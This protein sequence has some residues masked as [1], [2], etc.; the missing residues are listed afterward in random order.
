MGKDRDCALVDIGHLRELDLGVEVPPSP[1]TAV[2]SHEVWEEI[3]A[4][5]AELI[6]AHTT[7]LIFVNTRKMA[8]R[9]AA[10]LTKILGP[11][12]VTS[13]HGSLSRKHRL[14]AEQRLKEG[15]L[16]ALVATAS[17]ELGIDVGD[18]D[19]S[20]QVGASR[21]IATF[22]QR[23]GRAGHALRKTPKGRIFPLTLDE[24]VEAAAILR[25][26]RKGVLDRTPQPPAPL[27]ILA[28]QVVASCVPGPWEADRLYGQFRRAW[29]YRDL[30]REDF[31]RV[32]ELHAQ[33]RRAL[34]HR[35]GVGGRILATKRARLT[36][37]MSGGAIPDTAD[38]QVVMEPEGSPVGTVN[39]DFAIESNAG[40][41]FQLGNTSWRILK[42]EPGTVRVAD[43]KGQP[44]T[45]PFWTGEA[46][47]RT[48]ELSAEIAKIREEC[49][50]PDWVVRETGM[51]PASASQ[52]AE[53]VSAGRSALGGAPTQTRVILERFFDESG[54]MQLVVHAP[55]G[56]RINR[57][58]GLAL[59]KRFCR[60]FGFE[61]QAAANEEAI[62]LSLGPQHSFALEEVF[63]FLH[64]NTA[65]ALLVQA[66]LAAPMFGVRWRWNVTRSLLVER[67]TGGKRSPPPSSG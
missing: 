9:I 13:H 51:D 53:Y 39:E 8:E 10:R 12:A 46:P 24:L 19:L 34:L 29:P 36:A 21:S 32:V 30:P 4:R 1:L 41:I 58:W 17:L 31:D 45:L 37:I 56:G 3:Y 25:S 57:A 50:G 54:G 66:L 27:D 44:P 43:A 65:R 11:E 40:D 48:A 20:L 55:F 59:R 6:A 61:L 22:L 42:V 23:A 16:R 33:G 52:V 38:Y 2:C 49:T 14:E 26:I 67:M 47:A 60:G 63:D 35:D 18:V 7:T 15:R 5:M 62:V 28:Q 64:P